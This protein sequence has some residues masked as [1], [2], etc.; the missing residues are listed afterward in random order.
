[1]LKSDI[2]ELSNGKRLEIQPLDASRMMIDVSAIA[3]LE[4]TK[5]SELNIISVSFEGKHTISIN[6]EI[7]TVV[8]SVKTRYKIIDFS[9]SS[10]KTVLVLSTSIPTKTSTYLLPLLG[11]TKQQLYIGTYFVNSYMSKDKKHIGLLYRFTGTDKFKEFENQLISD[12]FCVKHIEYDPYHVLYI[13]RIQSEFTEDVR[14]FFDGKY[15]EFSDKT[16][17]LI[18]DFHKVPKNSLTQQILYKSEALRKKIEDE[19]GVDLPDELELLSKPI[20]EE[21]ILLII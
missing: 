2:I 4:T 15:S 1:M 12:K 9:L 20:E 21:E 8:G 6:D 17:K 10:D 19:L 11:K 16:K 5:D 3:F 13:F 14:R 7:E 18:I